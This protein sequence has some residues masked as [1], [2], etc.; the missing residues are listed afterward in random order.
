MNKEIKRGYPADNSFGQDASAVSVKENSDSNK[1]KLA[2]LL[3]DMRACRRCETAFG[4]EPRPVQWGGLDAKVMQ[5]SQAPSKNV[6]ACG[7]PF[8]DLSG[9]RLR[10]AWY[11]ISDEDFYNPDLFYITTVGHCFPGKGR[12]NYD[13]KPPKCCYDLWTSKEIELMDSCELYLIVG[14]EAANRIFK[15][16]KF[17][18]LVMHDQMLHGK[19][20]FVLP[21]PSPLNIKWFK[22]HPQFESE[23]LPV[24]RKALHE[25]L[26][27]A[28]TQNRG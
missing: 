21:H 18:D 9:K 23:R 22:D 28:K 15:G 5:I 1:K 11:K 6:H 27:R 10:Q 19:K 24:I 25:V 7:R 17:L 8:S 3:E 12:N 26:E 16:Q 2:L 20:C 13:K 4:Y 14:A